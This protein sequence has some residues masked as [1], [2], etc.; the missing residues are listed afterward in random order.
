MF[1][2]NESNLVNGLFCAKLNKNLKK[3][4]F[5][6]HFYSYQDGLKNWKNSKIL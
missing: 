3:K 2:E 6:T 1:D 5:V 4:Q